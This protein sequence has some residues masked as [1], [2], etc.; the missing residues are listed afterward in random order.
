MKNKTTGF[1]IRESELAQIL[2]V[3]DQELDETIVFFDSDPNDAWELKENEHFIYL[4]KSLN[5]RLFSEQG[6]YAIA[7]Y[8]D[9]SKGQSIWSALKE[10]ITK[11]KAKIRNAF[12][13]RKIQENSSS[14]TIR[15]NRHFLSKKDIVNILCTTSARINQ[16]FDE[17]Q[18]S[19]NPMKIY[20]DFEDFENTRYYSLSGFYKIS[21]NLGQ[22]LT[23]KNRR[24]WCNAIDLVGKQTF[25]ILI[26]QQTAL[27]NR[28][29]AAMNAAKARDKRTCQVT[30]KKRDKNNRSINIVAH[31]I[32]SKQHYPNLAT[33]VDNLISLTQEIH[34]EFHCWNGGSAKPCTADGFID[35]L[36]ELYPHS[37]ETILRLKTIKKILIVTEND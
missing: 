29:N 10:F 12:I 19:P 24:S 32:Y 14:L 15:N 5:E 8:I 2:E 16:A 20:E 7:K 11:H 34:T 31:H 33:C 3:T 9:E 17:I 27:E 35:F 36:T 26:D 1:N 23:A 28:I 13:S 18:R 22:S 30:Y 21:K 37:Y 25:K 6:A 4:N